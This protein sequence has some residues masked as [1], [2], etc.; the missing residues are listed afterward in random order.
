MRSPKTNAI[1]IEGKTLLKES[2]LSLPQKLTGMITRTLAGSEDIFAMPPPDAFIG[3]A[4]RW[5]P[6]PVLPKRP[7]PQSP[8]PR[9]MNPPRPRPRSP[10]SLFFDAMMS[11]SDI[12]RP[13]TRS[14]M[15]DCMVG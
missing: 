14:D 13:A 15:V 5:P 1:N 6:R 4:P 9:P 7:P 10:P 8:P 3:R 12:V 11:S 2:S